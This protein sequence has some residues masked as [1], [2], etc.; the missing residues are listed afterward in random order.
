M[1]KLVRES[2]EVDINSEEVNIETEDQES[3]HAI[4]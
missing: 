3:D 1:E 2:V 4:N